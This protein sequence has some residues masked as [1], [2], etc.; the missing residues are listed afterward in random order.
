MVYGH[1][2][3][4]EQIDIHRISLQ[5]SLLSFY[6][7]TILCLP[8]QA[9]ATVSSSESTTLRFSLPTTMTRQLEYLTQ[10]Q[11]DKVQ[12]NSI[13]KPV[14]FSVLIVHVWAVS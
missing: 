12:Q 10:D 2:L 5:L 14:S 13:T 9:T 1:V 3:F 8:Y 4:Y 7:K 11:I 6:I